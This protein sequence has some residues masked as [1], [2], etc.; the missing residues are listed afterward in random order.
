MRAYKRF[1]LPSI[2]I[3]ANLG[4]I[5]KVP[6]NS[7]ISLTSYSNS[8]LH[9]RTKASTETNELEFKVADINWKICPNHVHHLTEH[10]L[11]INRSNRLYSTRCPSLGS[12]KF[13]LLSSEK[14]PLRSKFWHFECRSLRTTRSINLDHTTLK[15]RLCLYWETDLNKRYE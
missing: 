14:L 7:T 13:G 8:L 1:R 9:L 10:L 2:S 3:A 11:I 5:N 4:I 15:K 12:E 6:R